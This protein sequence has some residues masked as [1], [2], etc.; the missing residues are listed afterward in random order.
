[1]KKLFSLSIILL[2]ITVLVAQNPRHGGKSS[3]YASMMSQLEPGKGAV[4]GL[5]I[6][7][8]QKP[9]SY[10]TVTL[11]RMSDSAIVAGQLTDTS[12]R[13]V[14]M[15]VPY[16]KYMLIVKFVGFKKKIITG[17]E[18][19]PKNRF[20]RVGKIEL[21]EQVHQ[22]DQVVVTATARDVEYRVDKKVINVSQDLANSSGNAVDV[23]QNVP[24]VQVD[25][26]G[27]VTLRGSGNFTVFIDG[28]PSVLDGNEALQQMPASE[29]ERIEIITN[30]SAKYDPD[31][32]AGI[33][34]IIT[35]QQRKKGYN[36]LFSVSYDNYGALGINALI[37]MR[38]NKF[39]FFASFDYQ[40]KKRP[41][42]LISL[43]EITTDSTLYRYNTDGYMEFVRGGW[44]VKTGFNYYIND[45]NTLTVYGVLGKRNFGMIS[46]TQISE[47]LYRNDALVFANYYQQS[48]YSSAAG[49]LY[50]GNIDFEHKFNDNGHKIRA[51]IDV[52]NWMPE[53]INGTL[54]DTTDAYWNI[55][56]DA[57]YG[58]ESRE[59]R[60]GFKGRMQVDYELPLP[61]GRKL[62]AGY[63]GR[64]FRMESDYKLFDRYG[65][66]DWTE[67][68][69][70]SNDLVMARNIQAL[71]FTYNGKLAQLF[72]YQL[73]LRTEY[74]HRI[75]S[76]KT[77]EQDF[78]IKRIDFFPT[79]HISRRFGD[80]F[81]LQLGYSRRVKRPRGWFLNPFPTYIDQY[82]IQQGNPNLLPAFSDSYEL[83][84]VKY[85]KK[86]FLSMD[87]FWRQTKNDFQRIQTVG[88]NNTIINTW[89]NAGKDMS[90]GVELSA[91][92]SLMRFIMFNASSSVYYYRII[93]T[94]DNQSVDNSTITWNSRLMTMVMFPT[95][96]RLQ[97]TGF[98]R[99][100][101][102]TLQ[103]RSEAFIM[104]SLALRQDF[105][106]RKASL[107]LSVRDPFKLMRFASVV[108]T[109]E[110]YS[111]NLYIMRSPNISA[112]LQ[113]R[114]NDYKPQR[115]RGS[116]G[117]DVSEFEGEGLY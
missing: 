21:S 100:P 105:F 63:V 75:V 73:G 67:L 34:N 69:D 83:S 70:F 99:A 102:V 4:M 104:T 17:I 52:S 117:D 54:V 107:T 81:Q 29:I 71:Y 9:V 12:G 20:V 41:A 68:T 22:I 101:T 2:W 7:Q 43:R 39:N 60:S 89:A 112:T 82:T 97:I 87:A 66:A 11:R 116:N 103:G 38:K 111:E 113:I 91:N 42:D 40:E 64:Y 108:E 62:E 56:S 47:M 30:P 90:G 3:M 114:L 46:G 5:V 58:Q 33:I 13:F 59:L 109:P 85:F 80:N 77:T 27:N 86:S 51:Y 92:L 78:T 8:Q 18:V 55:L 6:D 93:G 84:L 1:M 32:V 19:S 23:L 79:A 65:N 106:K 94:V 28:K 15:N 26:Q 76:Q 53:R 50:Q 57:S 96:T 16:G 14:L 25:I 88:D 115:N 10:S 48:G 95:G 36:G 49:F 72:D 35:K 37:N 110:L 98:Y 31:G 24:S 44:K 45:K 61:Q 74:T